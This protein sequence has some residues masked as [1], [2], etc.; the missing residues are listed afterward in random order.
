VA[1]STENKKRSNLGI[2]NNLHPSLTGIPCDSKPWYQRIWLHIGG[3]SFYIVMT[4]CFL[5]NAKMALR[6]IFHIK[7]KCAATCSNGFSLLWMGWWARRA[8]GKGNASWC[9]WFVY[10]TLF[11][12][13]LLYSS[14]SFIVVFW[15]EKQCASIP[16]MQKMLL[17][18]RTFRN[19]GINFLTF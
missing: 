1:D 16:S 14:M 12:L 2:L 7:I 5:V 10:L 8:A 19:I 9:Q 4:Q 17:L 18:F 6:L 15:L 3:D 11:Q 13:I